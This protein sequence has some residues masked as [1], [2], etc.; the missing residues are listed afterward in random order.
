MLLETAEIG[1][2]LRLTCGGVGEVV[3][4]LLSEGTLRIFV[5]R[6]DLGRTP[7]G[8]WLTGWRVSSEALAHLRE[9]AGCIARAS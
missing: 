8:I 1:G 2:S 9:R 3:D 5:S 6:R 4:A 7:S